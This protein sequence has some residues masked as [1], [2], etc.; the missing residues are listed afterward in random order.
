MKNHAQEYLG[1]GTHFNGEYL[2]EVIK[3]NI[4]D[5]VTYVEDEYDL[6]EFL[7]YASEFKASKKPKLIYFD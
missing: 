1:D 4:P 3:K 6:K 2:A 7:Q 5:F